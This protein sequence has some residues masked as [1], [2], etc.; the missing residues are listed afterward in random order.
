MLLLMGCAASSAT[1]DN[2]IPHLIDYPKA[3]QF[4][5][6]LGLN[7]LAQ[8]DITRAHLKLLK[9]QQ[10]APQLPCVHTA[11]AAFLERAGEIQEAQKSY[12]RAIRLDPKS[13]EVQ[14]YYA[15]FLC[16]QGEWV[17]AERAFL[18]AIQDRTYTQT[19]DVYENAGACLKPH[20]PAKA[21]M[22]FNKA[23]RYRV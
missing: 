4:N 8:G 3:A 13:G 22:Y 21:A 23:A 1:P 10:L 6:E 16:R 15:N 5:V 17:N 18:K 12:Q 11:Y 7:Y 20:D 14:H 2:P 9:A 19:V